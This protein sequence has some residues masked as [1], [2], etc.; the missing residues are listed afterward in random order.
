MPSKSGVEPVEAPEVVFYRKD[1]HRVE[2]CLLREAAHRVWPD[3]GSGCDGVRLD[4][5][6]GEAVERAETVGEPLELV[7]GRNEGLGGLLITDEH[8]AAPREQCT[9]RTQHRDR[10]GH[11]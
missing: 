7:A 2:A 9:R 6:R 8:R 11:V 10:I 3:D 5:A 1:G 4:Q